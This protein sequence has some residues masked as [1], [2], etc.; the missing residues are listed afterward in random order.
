MTRAIESVGEKSQYDTQVKMLLAEKIILAWI[1]KY[2][3]AEFQ[4]C[5]I[6]EIVSLIEGDPQVSEVPVAPGLTTDR[7]TGMS[8]ED[9][10]PFEG[11]VTYDIRFHA[12][13]PGHERMKLIINVEAQKKYH[14]GYD[15]VTR[16]IFYGARMLSAQLD[17]E[18]KADNYDDIKKVYSIWICM[19]VP[20]QA[21]NTIVKY[22][23]NQ[24]V[25]Y[26]EFAGKHRYDLLNVVMIHLGDPG[27]ANQGEAIHHL[28]HT[29]LSKEL[30][31]KEKEDILASEFDITS[32]RVKEGVGQMCN[33]SELIEEKGI[34]KGIEKGRAE[35]LVGIVESLMIGKKY[36]EEEACDLIDVSWQRYRDAKALL[37]GVATD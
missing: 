27:D 37:A 23:L 9:A 26:G 6:E 14:P 21:A 33:L 10:V 18:F 8:T 34:A 32:P 19:D 7:I 20:R 17:T 3:A 28:L 2:S 24:T 1:L 16:G 25:L 30:T 13:T 22:D 15:L 35:Q 11:R 4:E 29:L 31:A 5:S 12:F 36:S